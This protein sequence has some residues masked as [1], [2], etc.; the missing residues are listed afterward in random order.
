MAQISKEE[1]IETL[2]KCHNQKAAG[3]SGIPY[4]LLKK[5]GETNIP[6]LLTMLNL[7]IFK[8]N[9]PSNWKNT[10]IY[11]IP[12]KTD[13]EGKLA[14]IRPITL[15]ETTKKLLTKIL[16]TRLNRILVKNNILR[17]NN[18]AALPGTS[19]HEPLHILN[20][21]MEEAWEKKKEVWMLFLDISKAYDSMSTYMLEKA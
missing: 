16:T 17:G 6:Y 8:L 10:M 7:C 18:C 12:K 3:E 21:I 14:D 15:I 11:P 20:N 19:T 9:I 2:T 4:E 5:M 1:L 13:W